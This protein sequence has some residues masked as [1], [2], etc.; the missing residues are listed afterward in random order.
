MPPLQQLEPLPAANL[1]KWRQQVRW[2]TAPLEQI[3]VKELG[4]KTLDDGEQIEVMHDVLR[5][6]I[7]EYLPRLKQSDERG[8]ALFPR[9]ADVEWVYRKPAAPSGADP[10][11]W[12][13]KVA[14][15]PDG[16]KLSSRWAAELSCMVAWAAEQ[17]EMC[18]EVNDA[19]LKYETLYETFFVAT[20][21]L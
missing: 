21:N 20:P 1:A 6:D 15:M 18:R 3:I 16:K 5:E 17:L 2:Y 13:R 19:S 11:K 12:W 9:F 8:I 14:A 10:G 7:R 4:F